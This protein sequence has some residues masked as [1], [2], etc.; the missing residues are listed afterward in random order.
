MIAAI[1]VLTVALAWVLASRKLTRRS[2]TAPIVL[3]L[4]GWALASGPHPVI[5]VSVEPSSVRTAVEI[6][7]ALVLF[8]DA[9]TVGFGWFRTSWR[10]PAQLLFIGLPLTI[11]LG[12]VTAWGLFPGLAPAVVGVVASALAPTDAALGAAVLDDDRIPT[13]IRQTINVESGLNDGLATPVVLLFIALAGG[14]DSGH[15]HFVIELIIAL[16]VG[17]GIGGAG[18]TLVHLA[19][20]RRW[21]I[22]DEEPIAALSLALLAYF[23]AVEADGNGFVAA[24]VAGLAFGTRLAHRESSEVLELTHQIGLLLGFAVWFLF[25]AVLL[26]IAFDALT[27]QVVIFAILSLTVL[28]MV[29]VAIASLGVRQRPEAIALVGWLGPRGLASIVFAILAI[30]QLPAATAD[31]IGRII[32]FT[33]GVSVLVHGLSAGPVATWYARRVG[34]RDRA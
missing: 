26:P 27:W 19:D 34:G 28:R 30:E 1:V 17:L 7:L 14:H 24:F 33:V 23:V 8:V 2:V 5:T 20:Q 29:P 3:S 15:V 16:A 25:G 12:Y 18:G 9:S 11:A 13:R 4:A 21:S 10:W 32:A 22:R 6:T 31:P